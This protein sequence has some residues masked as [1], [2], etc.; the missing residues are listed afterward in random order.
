GRPWPQ[1]RVAL[2]TG[3]PRGFCV[4]TRVTVLTRQDDLPCRSAGRISTQAIV[5]GGPPNAVPEDLRT[6]LHTADMPPMLRNVPLGPRAAGPASA[7]RT[8]LGKEG[9][10]CLCMS[11]SRFWSPS[12]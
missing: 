2:A 7:A 12:M 6:N 5:G 11:P 8:F 10:F 4:M 3:T 1:R 9:E